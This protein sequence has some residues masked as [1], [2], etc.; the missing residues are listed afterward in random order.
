MEAISDILKVAPEIRILAFTAFSD[1]DQILSAVKS[2]AIGY[3]LKDSTPQEI[4]AAIRNASQGKPAFNAQIELNLMDFIRQNQSIGVP[5]EK[6]T[7][8]EIEILRWLA[9][10][11]TDFDIAQKA[12]ITE[13]TV[14]SH[15]SNLLAKLGLGNRAQAVLYALRAGLITPDNQ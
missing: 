14:R 8:R 11:L 5:V 7:D 9:Q 3:L 12:C 1:G 15:I 6:L 4:F 13:G 2:G 10:G